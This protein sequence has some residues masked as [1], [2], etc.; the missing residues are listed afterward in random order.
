MCANWLARNVSAIAAD[1]GFGLCYREIA[2]VISD[3]EHMINRPYPNIYCGPC[4]AIVDG[5]KCATGLDVKRGTQTVE[6]WKCHTV[7]YVDT[8]I[9]DAVD[10]V[11]QLS[12]TQREV[13]DILAVIG[14][15]IPAST[16]RNWRQKGVL[17]DRSENGAEPR[18]WLS[19]IRE[20]RAAGLRKQPLVL[21]SDAK[22][23]A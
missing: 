15:P 16:W 18:Y 19:D 13:R 22:R 17:I 14:E 9:R 2:E 6:C 21:A 3:I 8:L 12:F 11:F 5:E 10:S 7:H 1:E 20:L 23:L 4:P